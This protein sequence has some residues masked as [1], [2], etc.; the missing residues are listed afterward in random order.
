MSPITHVHCKV[1]FTIKPSI[2][3]NCVYFSALKLFNGK[4]QYN[5]N[6]L[7]VLQ[8]PHI[9]VNDTK[10]HHVNILWTDSSLNITVD[11]IYTIGVASSSGKDLGRVSQFFIGARKNSTTTTVY[12]GFRGCIQGKAANYCFLLKGHMF[13]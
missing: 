3:I 12:G 2:S 1:L 9:A 13:N 7:L 6:E 5:Y 4:L 8:L 10:W 11:Y